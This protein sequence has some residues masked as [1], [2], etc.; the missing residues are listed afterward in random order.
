MIYRGSGFLVVIRLLAHPLPSF[1]VSKMSLFHSLPV[2]RRGR[3]IV[4]GEGCTG[5]GEE[6][7]HATARKPG[8]L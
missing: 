8:P 7:N 6:P 2:C 1:L 3:A 4:T 5:V